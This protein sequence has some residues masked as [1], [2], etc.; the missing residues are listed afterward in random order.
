M[1]EKSITILFPIHGLVPRG[2]QKVAYEYANRLCRDGYEL[3]IVY[4]ALPFVDKQSFLRKIRMALKYLFYRYIKG[5]SCRNW[6]NLDNRIREH[7]TYSLDWRYVP[8]TD[9]YIATAVETAMFLNTYPMPIQN[10]LY[11]IQGFE[12]W[13]IS[14]E[15]VKQTFNYGFKNI[16]VSNWLAKILNSVGAKYT[17]IKNGFDFGYFRMD[18]SFEERN[19][20]KIAMMYSQQTCKGSEYGLKALA[21][22][23]EKYPALN[24]SLFGVHPKPAHLPDYIEYYQNPNREVHNRIYNES[25]IFLASSIEEGW[26]LPVGEAM[27]CGCAVVCTDNKGFREMA[28]DGVSALMSPIKDA[29][30]LADNII[31]L[32][33]DDALRVR[34]A[35]N[36][37]NNIQKFRWEDS[38]KKLKNLL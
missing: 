10:K 6:F 14:D 38:Y 18:I 1:C 21:I 3:H 11:L 35:K 13:R 16:V 8:K 31:R 20:F 26:G 32:I 27:I 30:S 7:Y 19:T 22:V 28:E 23:K 37:H 34:I 9:Y 24:V 15:C 29:E 25:S 2:G 17:L 5:Y 12:N 33:E 36:G 4:P